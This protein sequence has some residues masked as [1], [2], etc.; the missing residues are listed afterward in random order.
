RMWT[1]FKI[2]L[3]T[4]ATLA[5]SLPIA[6]YICHIL[7]VFHEVASLP[8]GQPPPP[9]FVAAVF[10]GYGIFFL[11]FG[12]LFLVSSLMGDFIL[13]SL[14]LENCS[15]REAFRRMGSLISQEPGEFIIYTLLKIGL[16]LAFSMGAAIAGEIVLLICTLV[17][18]VVVFASTDQQHD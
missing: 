12:S 6:A 2:L 5:C 14:A 3:G 7:P 15:L 16:A 18:A 17:L 9:Q 10:A 13:P 1:G 8:P 11:I 4:G